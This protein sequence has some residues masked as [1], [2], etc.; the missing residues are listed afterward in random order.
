[1]RGNFSFENDVQT[2]SAALLEQNRG[3]GGSYIINA[4]NPSWNLVQAS[5]GYQT[6]S[7]INYSLSGAIPIYGTNSANGIQISLGAQFE[8]GENNSKKKTST[9]VRQGSFKQYDLEGKVTSVN[10]QLYLVKIDQGLDQGIEKG[11]IFDIFIENKAIAKAKVT[12]VKN[13]ESA[14]RVLEYYKEQSIEVDAIAKRL[15]QDP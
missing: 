9:V 4:R 13:D 15:V 1:M 2:P 12:N 14:L 11:Q 5:I 7:N 10:D 8:F 6:K 3:A